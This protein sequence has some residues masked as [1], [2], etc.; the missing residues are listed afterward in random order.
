MAMALQRSD[1]EQIIRTLM[2]Q[3]MIRTT[4]RWNIDYISPAS[5]T[6]KDML[7]QVEVTLPP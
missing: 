1:L 7:M 3:N 6:V 2:Q 5:I 4:Y